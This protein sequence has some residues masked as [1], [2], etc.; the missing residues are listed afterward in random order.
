MR[1]A[2]LEIVLVM[3]MGTAAWAQRIES[4]IE[5][6]QHQWKIAKQMKATLEKGAQPFDLQVL[7]SVGATGTNGVDDPMYD[8]KLLVQ[9]GGRVVYESES[10]H[11][12]DARFCV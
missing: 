11:F 4:T 2:A 8:V 5:Y 7:E 12:G 1:S 9:S 10:S 3:L 6:K